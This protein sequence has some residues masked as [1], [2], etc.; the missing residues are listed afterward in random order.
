VTLPVPP[1]VP[2]RIALRDATACAGRWYLV[3]AVFTAGGETRPAAWTSTDGKAW[4][5]VRMVPR[6][7]YGF[8]NILYAVGCHADRVA[9]VG[10]KAGGAHGNPRVRTWHQQPDGSLAEVSAYFELYGGPTAVSVNR[11]AGGPK[12][13]L[14]AGSRESGAAVWR[15][16]DAAGFKIAEGV[17]GLASD[18]G[19]ATQATD[20][21]AASDGWFVGGAGRPA[22]R[23][24]RDAVVWTTPDGERFARVVLPAGADDEAVQ[25]LVRAGGGVL[26][27]GVRGGGFAAWRLD[28]GEAVAVPGKWS[29]GAT[30]GETGT[31]AVAGVEAAAAGDGQVFAVTVA[32]DG[33]RLWRGD[34]AGGRWAPVAVPA[35]APAGGDT[36][37]AVAAAQGRVLV[38]MDDGRTA[39]TWIAAAPAGA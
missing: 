1:G 18:A 11:V 35:G 34:P 26:A 37:A 36:A 12:G 3:G 33:H 22:G 8:L 27:L 28:G 31:G 14:L 29:A 2:G 21:L 4:T 32:A 39:R 5:S 16:P 6:S 15:S 30:F 10:A 24:D 38:V 20:A 9:V 17:P 7:Y 19:L 13:W 23:T 25:R